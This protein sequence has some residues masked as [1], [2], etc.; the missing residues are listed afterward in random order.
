MVLSGSFTFEILFFE[1][2]WSDSF[3]FGASDP[4]TLTPIANAVAALAPELSLAANLETLGGDD[5]ETVLANGVNAAKPLVMPQGALIWR[6][7]RVPLDVTLERFESVPLSK[8]QALVVE[9]PLKHE[10]TQEWF[11]P[12][13][14]IDLSQSE[15][16]NRSGFERLDA[17]ITLGFGS[18]R[19]STEHKH[20]FTVKTL[21]LPEPQPIFLPFIA[22]PFGLLDAVA[23]R[24]GPLQLAAAAPVLKIKDEKWKVKQG[25]VGSGHLSQAEAHQKVR[26]GG[27]GMALAKV[28]ADDFINVGGL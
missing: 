7:K 25:A 5:R 8:P 11:S 4:Q 24:A 19:A 23:E 28:E 3:V 26:H 13:T 1:I 6:Q 15:A 18:R 20:S 12:G 22:F 21:R 10:A 16:L 27:G 14:F 9:S 17:G 2:S